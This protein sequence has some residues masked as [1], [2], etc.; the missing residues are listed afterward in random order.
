MEVHFKKLSEEAV[1]KYEWLFIICLIA[2]E[3]PSY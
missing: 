1:E 2:E 3:K